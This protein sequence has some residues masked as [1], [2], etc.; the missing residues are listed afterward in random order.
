MDPVTLVGIA[1]ALGALLV[2][3]LME[4]ASPLALVL[5]AP[6]LLVFG[7]TVGAAMAGS[8]MSDLRRLGRW[9]RLALTPVKLPPVSD[10]IA[11]LVELAGRARREGLLALDRHLS[12]VPDPFLRRG[13][14]LAIDGVDPDHLRAVLEGEIAARRS[15]DKVAARFFAQMGGYAPTIGIIG[16]VVGLIQVLSA[17][18]DTGSIGSLVGGAFVATLWGV[19]SANFF[20]LPMSERILRTAELRSAQLELLLTGIA[21]IQA[22]TSPRAMQQRL[23]SLLP[24]SEQKDPAAPQPSHARVGPLQRGL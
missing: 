7:G 20:W 13:L 16:T 6:I 24:P 21:E 18:S 8:T 17:L 15:E 10:R 4:G 19:L 11:T 22:G 5:L 14:Q 9:F 1:V 23:T 2:A 12:S 3:M